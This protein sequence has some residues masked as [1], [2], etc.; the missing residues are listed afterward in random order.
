M[1]RSRLIGFASLRLLQP[2]GLLDIAASAVQY[3]VESPS[4]APN[5]R[6]RDSA[7]F[8]SGKHREFVYQTAV[9]YSAPSFMLSLPTMTDHVPALRRGIDIVPSPIEQSPGLI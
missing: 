3:S 6:V 5:G 2:G 8:P 7:D 1:I 9:E 4:P